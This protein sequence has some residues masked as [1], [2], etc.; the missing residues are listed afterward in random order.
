MTLIPTK[1]LTLKDRSAPL[2][3]PSRRR[4]SFGSST[5]SAAPANRIV[6]PAAGSPEDPTVGGANVVVY[7]SAG[8]TSDLAFASLDASRWSRTG[9]NTYT[10]RNVSIAAITKVVLKSDS[11]TIKGGKS[12]WSYTLNEQAQGQIAVVLTLGSGGRAFCADAAAKLAGNPPSTAANDR[13]DKFVGRQSAPP[14]ACPPPP[15]P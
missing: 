14:A 1:R 3:D 7:N 11:I 9:T 12:L 5:K 8:L 15:G 10:Y 2:F 4:I 6:P 13:V